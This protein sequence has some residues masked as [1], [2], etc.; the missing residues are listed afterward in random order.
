MFGKT[1]EEQHH[2]LVG[3]LDGYFTKRRS[4]YQLERS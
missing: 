2:N 4:T 3:I 1:T